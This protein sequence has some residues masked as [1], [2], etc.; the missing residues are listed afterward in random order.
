MRARLLLSAVPDKTLSEEC[1]IKL[2][3]ER[4]SAPPPAY[5]DLHNNRPKTA[6]TSAIS[7]FETRR[8]SNFRPFWLEPSRFI[9]Q[10]RETGRP[11]PIQMQKMVN[12]YAIRS[13]HHP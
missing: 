7:G 2:S 11:T 12:Y 9:T 4:A 13:S 3:E 10:R 5:C 6:E 1:A 8:G